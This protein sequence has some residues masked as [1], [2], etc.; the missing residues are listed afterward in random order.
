MNWL[1]TLIIFYYYQNFMR[2]IEIYYLE[3]KYKIKQF[4]NTIYS[5]YRQVL[6]K[7]KVC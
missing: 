2:I 6:N 1:M 3:L 4:K 7:L 5:N